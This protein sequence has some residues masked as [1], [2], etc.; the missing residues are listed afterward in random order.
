MFSDSIAAYSR[1]GGALWKVDEVSF[2]MFFNLAVVPGQDDFCFGCQRG[3]CFELAYFLMLRG[4]ANETWLVVDVWHIL[5]PFCAD[6]TSMTT[7]HLHSLITCL[8]LSRWGV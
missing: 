6:M 3:R 1:A 2:W 7:R 4:D 5:A 8:V